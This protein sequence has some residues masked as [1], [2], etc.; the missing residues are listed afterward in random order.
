MGKEIG[1]WVKLTEYQSVQCERKGGF[2][3]WVWVWCV[4]RL[5]LGKPCVELLVWEI[6]T[7][8]F[9]GPRAMA[10]KGFLF[11]HLIRALF[12][13]Q[14]FFF[15]FFVFSDC[16]KFT[17]AW[18]WWV[19]YCQFECLFLVI[20]GWGRG[21]RLKVELRPEILSFLCCTVHSDASTG[22]FPWNRRM[23]F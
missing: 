22:S 14:G 15:P 23:C 17:R 21:K 2:L 16:L 1:F 6:F 4:L 11:T 12:A 20:R 8:C 3:V 5:V 18:D 19:L 13:K 10:A 9:S 7:I